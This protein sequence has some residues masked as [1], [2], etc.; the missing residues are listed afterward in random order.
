[1]SKLKYFTWEEFD[2]PDLEKSGYMYMDR[3]FVER[4]DIARGIAG[5]PFVI[6]SGYRTHNHNIRV[7][8]SKN[9]SHKKGLACDISTPDSRTK[10]LA[11]RALLEVGFTRIGIYDNFVHVDDDEE[12]IQ[13][14]IW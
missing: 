2:S 1:M 11:V 4:L 8:G 3:D 9:S 14:V 7:G 10:F 6:N 12:K 13:E 5:V